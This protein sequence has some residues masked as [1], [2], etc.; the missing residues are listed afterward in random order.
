MEEEN[1]RSITIF[2]ANNYFFNDICI[3]F[4]FAFFIDPKCNLLIVFELKAPSN[5]R[6]TGSNDPSTGKP[7]YIL[8]I[9]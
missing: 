6:T 9:Y 7:R 5:K 4:R 1:Y 3:V 2:T 8:T